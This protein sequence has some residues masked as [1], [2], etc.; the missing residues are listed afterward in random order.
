MG[1]HAPGVR[2]ARVPAVVSITHVAMATACATPQRAR[3]RTS[4]SR[5]NRR[6]SGP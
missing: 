3:E 6:K 1:R 4:P 2:S 5:S